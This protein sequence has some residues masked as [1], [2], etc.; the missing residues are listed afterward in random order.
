[1][2]IYPSRHPPPP[3]QSLPFQRVAH[4]LTRIDVQPGPSETVLIM[5][6]GQLKV[7]RGGD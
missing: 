1:M 5:V 3:F 6:L 7:W 2:L 4:S